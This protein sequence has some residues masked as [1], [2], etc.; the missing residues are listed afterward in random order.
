MALMQDFNI[1]EN[2][3]AKNIEKKF[4]IRI[5]NIIALKLMHKVKFLIDFIKEKDYVHQKDQ[6]KII[7]IM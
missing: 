6:I 5:I 3:K 2:H 1:M 7:L 4:V